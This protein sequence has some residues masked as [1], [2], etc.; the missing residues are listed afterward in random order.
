MPFGAIA[1]A[2]LGGALISSSGAQSAASTQASAANSATATQLAMFNRSRA[3]LQP[4]MDVGTS[5]KDLLMSRLPD[6][7]NISLPNLDVTQSDVEQSPGYN[8]LMGEGLKGVANSAAAK[9]LA[10]SGPALR[11]AASYAENLADTY[12]KDIVANRQQEYLNQLGLNQNSFNMLYNLLGLGESAAAGSGANAI[13]TGNSI[14]SNII[15]AG[16]AS[17]AGTIASSNAWGSALSSI[18]SN[19][20][21]YNALNNATVSTGGDS[22][23]PL[24]SIQW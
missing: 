20:Y 22:I 16:N 6:L 14:G 11:G 12:W 19:L 9:G 4:Y 2:T 21:L 1:G 13:Q 5:V 23:V 8:F 15:G 7:M 18:P 24:S 17:A 10:V 3:D